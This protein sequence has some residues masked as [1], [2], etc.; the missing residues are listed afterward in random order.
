MNRKLTYWLILEA[1]FV[2]V[3]VIAIFF[4]EDPV[5]RV[6]LGIS[7]GLGAIASIIMVTKISAQRRKPSPEQD[8]K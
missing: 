7:G 8:G 3:L 1:V 6:L 4:L 5:T 2:A